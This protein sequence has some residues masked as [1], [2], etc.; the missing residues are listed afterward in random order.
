[1][2]NLDK[3]TVLEITGVKKTYGSREQV[4]EALRGINLKIN[5]GSFISIMGPSGSGKTTLLNIIATID[6]PTFGV[7]SIE[8]QDIFLLNNKE[9]A[10]FRRK[11][12]GFIFQDFSLLDTMTSF[13]NIALPLSINKVDGSQIKEKVNSAAKMLDIEEILEKYPS[14][15]SGGQKQRVSAARAIV[16]NPSLILADEPTGA[17]DSKSSRNLLEGISAINKKTNATIILVTHDPFAA[18]YSDKVLFL[19]DGRII[20]ELSKNNCTRKEFYDEIISVIQNMG[21]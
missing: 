3:S 14:Q 10:E 21:E 15:M 4:T 17:L 20:R 5:K 1:M 6:K 13:E 7:V 19:S 9:L 2:E 16:N 18:S 11:K 12:L 8:G